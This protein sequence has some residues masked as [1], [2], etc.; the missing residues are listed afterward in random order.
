MNYDFQIWLNKR[1][2]KNL[3]TKKIIDYQYENTLKTIDNLGLSILEEEKFFRDFVFF[4]YYNS[5]NNRKKI[6]KEV[7]T[8]RRE[9]FEFNFMN[10]LM[11]L[12]YLL[13]EDCSSMGIKIFNQGKISEFIDLIFNNI[14]YEIEEDLSEEEYSEEE[15]YE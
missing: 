14:V 7:F 9:E 6:K 3:S 10:D 1:F 8:E 15:F 4:V 12:Y 11:N 13:E 5:Q 2:D